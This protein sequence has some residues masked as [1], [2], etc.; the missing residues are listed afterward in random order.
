MINLINSNFD[1]D[2]WIKLAAEDPYKFELQRHQWLEDTIAEA[3]NEQKP[4]LKGLLWEIN[5]DL[6][7]AKNKYNNCNY[8]SR[9]VVENLNLFKE[10]MAGNLP[11]INQRPATII[12]FVPREEQPQ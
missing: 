12:E 9:R 1:I 5:M 6:E 10:T 3:N 4:R 7:L 8:I 2:L 11:F